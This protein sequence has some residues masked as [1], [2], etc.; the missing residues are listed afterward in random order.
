MRQFSAQFIRHSKGDFAGKSF[1]LQ[2]WQ[3][4][5]VV[6]PLFGWI[7]PDGT[8]RYRTGYI[9]IPKKNGKTTMCS[10]LALY[11]LLADGEPGAEIYSAAADRE[12]AS[13]VFREAASMV[14]QSPWLSKRLEVV[15]SQK[16]IVDR[17]SRSFY[18]ALSAD[19][20]TKEGLNIHAL[21]FDE[22]HAQKSRDLFDTLRY[23]GASRRQPLLLSITTAGTDRDSICYEQHAY[24]RQIEAG[25]VLDTAFFGYIRSASE[26]DDWTEEATWFRAN[27]SLGVTINIDGFRSD[28]TEARNSPAKQN[29]FRRYRLNQWLDQEERWILREDWDACADESFDESTLDGIECCLGIDLASNKDLAAVVALFKLSDGRYYVLPKLYTCDDACKHRERGNKA[30]FGNWVRSG[31]LVSCSGPAIDFDEIRR[32]VGDIGRRHNVRGIGIDRW[33][34]THLVTQLSGDGF[35]IMPTGM[36]YSSL[37]SPS[38]RF[39]N[40]IMTRQLVHANHPVL[41]WNVSNLGYDDDAAGNIK[42][43]KAKSMDK[44]DGVIG[45]ILALA[46]EDQLPSLDWYTPGCLRDQDKSKDRHVHKKDA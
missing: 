6:R 2:P 43:S 24:W 9:E 3:W 8:R 11:L 28:F 42:P 16:R 26:D 4:D 25:H 23:G 10:M 21:I 1:T 37:S 40:M 12:Q 15:A 35:A 20:P 14:E 17:A 22:L 38:K 27:P 46:V 18:K 36:G 30:K 29:A 39:E 13:I 19:V 41:N 32:Y 44:I 7:R 31:H 45:V 34:A 5:D 33:N